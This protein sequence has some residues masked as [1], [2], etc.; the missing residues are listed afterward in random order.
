MKLQ[1]SNQWE[2]CTFSKVAIM[3]KKAINNHLLNKQ[4]GLKEEKP[5]QLGPWG[6]QAWYITVGLSH[7]PSNM[8]PVV[9]FSWSYL[10]NQD[11]IPAI[12]GFRTIFNFNLKSN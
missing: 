2:G 10:H 5:P 6:L 1:G 8:L 12:V 3:A 9:P 4:Y 7:N 11:A